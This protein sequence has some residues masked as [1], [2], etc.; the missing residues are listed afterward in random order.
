[1][2]SHLFTFFLTLFALFAGSDPNEASSGDNGAG[3]E[4]NG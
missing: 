1:M 2:P 3:L 4:P